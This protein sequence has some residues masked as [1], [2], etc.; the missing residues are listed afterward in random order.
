MS[1][2]LPSLLIEFGLSLTWSTVKWAVIVARFLYLVMK[3]FFKVI[4][5]SAKAT[6]AIPKTRTLKRRTNRILR[7]DTILT[8]CHNFVLRDLSSGVVHG[9]RR[10]HGIRE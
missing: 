4:W 1:P 6:V 5:L 10:P 7:I 8:G 3:D 2:S 9:T